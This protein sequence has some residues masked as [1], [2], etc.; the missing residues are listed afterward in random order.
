MAESKDK[1][2]KKS[3]IRI[4]GRHAGLCCTY[5]AKL[6]GVAPVTVR[7]WVRQKKGKID[8]ND[9]RKFIFEQEARHLTEA[10]RANTGIDLTD[11]ISSLLQ[12][13]GP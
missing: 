12:R 10:I 5:I 2:L 9:L 1:H 6:A 4:K 7:R 13:E 11:R 3:R 8:I